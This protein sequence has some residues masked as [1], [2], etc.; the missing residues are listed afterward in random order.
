MK[1]ATRMHGWMMCMMSRLCISIQ[2]SKT[3]T[4]YTFSSCIHC[5]QVSGQPKMQHAM[6][7]LSKKGNALPRRRG[8]P[9]KA[10]PGSHFRESRAWFRSMAKC[11]Q[12]IRELKPNGCAPESTSSAASGRETR[13]PQKTSITRDTVKTNS[14]ETI[15]GQ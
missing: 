9:I 7:K 6:S 5:A 4:H 14:C 8:S 12:P 1:T 11:Q 3:N 2:I 10:S 15:H 13:S